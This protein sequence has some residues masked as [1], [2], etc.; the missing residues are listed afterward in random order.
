MS[1]EVATVDAVEAA[2]VKR[3][4]IGHYTID[5]MS[6]ELNPKCKDKSFKWESP[7]NHAKFGSRRVFRA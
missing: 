6:S 7:S 3:F 2:A 4:K 5:E 1:S